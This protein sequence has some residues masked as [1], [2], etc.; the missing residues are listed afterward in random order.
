MAE[1]KTKATEV[2]PRL[3][4]VDRRRVLRQLAIKSVAEMRKRYDCD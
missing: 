2:D 4:D 3:D 1:L